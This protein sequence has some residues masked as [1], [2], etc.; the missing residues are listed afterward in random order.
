MFVPV[1]IVVHVRMIVEFGKS[2][3]ASALL[4]PVTLVHH[5]RAGILGGVVALVRDAGFE[6]V[7]SAPLGFAGLAYAL[8]YRS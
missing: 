1:V 4:Y 3:T 7:A 8:A 6:R 5:R 2:R